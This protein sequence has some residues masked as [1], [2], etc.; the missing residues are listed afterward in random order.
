MLIYTWT[1][2]LF[3]K[4]CSHFIIAVV[5]WGGLVLW[6]SCTSYL[7]VFTFFTCYWSSSSCLCYFLSWF[8]QHINLLIWFFSSSIAKNRLIINTAIYWTLFP[9]KILPAIC[10]LLPPGSR[11]H[12]SSY[13]VLLLLIISLLSQR[14]KLIIHILLSFILIF[15]ILLI[16]LQ[17]SNS[18]VQR[19]S[20]TF[21]KII[22]RIFINVL[23]LSLT[24]RSTLLKLRNQ[25]LIIAHFIAHSTLCFPF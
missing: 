24:I 15:I 1:G 4:T 9:S 21:I 18:C 3:V 23:K 7:R 8:I 17:V 6:F 19:S 10:K 22:D 16:C 11:R 14:L 12:S 2:R 20:I 13:K 25:L 5:L